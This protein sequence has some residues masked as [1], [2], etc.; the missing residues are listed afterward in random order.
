MNGMP[1]GGEMGK[2][3][4]IRAKGGCTARYTGKDTQGGY[5]DLG[6]REKV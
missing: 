1:R 3:P 4:K 5:N 6:T 2:G